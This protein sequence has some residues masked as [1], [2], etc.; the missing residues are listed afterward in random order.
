M[1]DDPHSS[2]VPERK[3]RV[4]CVFVSGMILVVLLVGGLLAIVAWQ[5][6]A[7]R[8]VARLKAEIS[9]RG[10]PVSAKEL[11]GWYVLPEGRQDCTAE[12]LAAMGALTSQEFGLDAKDLPVVGTGP[13]GIP[14]AGEPW[15]QLAAVE[16]VLT[17]YQDA[18][19]RLHAAAERGGA[20]RYPTNLGAGVTAPLDHIQ[21]L[22]QGARVLT[23]EAHV[24]AH[25]GDPAGATRSIR[26][27]I[28]LATSLRNE[29]TIVSHL[30]RIAISGMAT[31]VCRKTLPAVEFS[32]R[33]L[34]QLSTDLQ[35]S[36]LPDGLYRA[37][38]GE[39]AIG[40]SAF[41]DPGMLGG[42]LP[43]AFLL[44]R[45]D[46]LSLYLELMNEAV[47]A[48]QGQA[49]SGLGGVNIR[50]LLQTRTG[51]G[52]L[53]YPVTQMLLPALEAV[54]VANM[55]GQ[56]DGAATATAI[57]IERYRRKTGTLPA[58]LDQLAPEYLPEVPVDLF[59]GQPLRYVV[60]EQQ[61]LL[62][63][64]GQN[65]VDDGGQDDQQQDLVFP[66][67]RVVP[68]KKTRPGP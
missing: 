62:Y 15:E 32:D 25:R 59:D 19:R 6:A 28:A 39:R 37:M 34:Q 1:T 63:S 10:E 58:R 57:A 66:V 17:K 13:E 33:A 44:N 35:Q 24:R 26:T 20:A 52:R 18:I 14:T 40:I 8:R 55:R 56:V 5:A 47:A 67:R 29:P 30:V 68:G 7:A 16:N 64:V 36:D 60:R 54:Q 50:F 61:Y 4:G 27:M 45:N 49:K 9:A 48:T 12:W 21:S 43:T 42:S 11:D 23:L 41:Q 22:R 51:I 38:V 2:V 65:R 46:D 3:P 53:R 31:D